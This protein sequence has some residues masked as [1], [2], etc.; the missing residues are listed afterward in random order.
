[1]FVSVSYTHV[2]FPNK[3]YRW[4]QTLYEICIIK[5]IK[6]MTQTL[7]RKGGFGSIVNLIDHFPI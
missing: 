5:S 4:K 3:N 1:M 6:I 2:P 7:H